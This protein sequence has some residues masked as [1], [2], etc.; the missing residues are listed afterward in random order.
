M[1]RPLRW[2]LYGM[3]LMWLLVGSVAYGGDGGDSEEGD[4][5]PGHAPPPACTDTRAPCPMEDWCSPRRV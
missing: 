1:S 5:D 3:I 4:G 2:I